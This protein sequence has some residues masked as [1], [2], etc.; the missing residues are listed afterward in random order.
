M[1]GMMILVVDDERPTA[2][3]VA[4]LLRKHGHRTLSLNSRADAL[5]HLRHI[6]FDLVILDIS[7]AGLAE[8]ILEEFLHPEVMLLDTALTSDELVTKVRE[9]ELRLEQEGQQALEFLMTGH[10]PRTPSQ[11]G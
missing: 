5:K 11:G 7:S 1:A 3:Q 2:D 8:R 10:E 6:W 9:I 4:D